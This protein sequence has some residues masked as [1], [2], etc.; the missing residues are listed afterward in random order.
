[1]ERDKTYDTIQRPC[2]IF[3]RTNDMG[4]G[5]RIYVDAVTGLIIGGDAFGD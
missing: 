1:M 5:V 2:Y 4:C 3:T